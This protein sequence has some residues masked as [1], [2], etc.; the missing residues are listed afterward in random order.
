MFEIGRLI[1][2]IRTALKNETR[3]IN[4]L[5]TFTQHHHQIYFHVPP[6]NISKSLRQINL[7]KMSQFKFYPKPKPIQTNENPENSIASKTTARKKVR[8]TMT[9]ITERP[10][11]RFLGALGN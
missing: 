1:N 3:R 5:Q 2:V 4:N 8:A 6:K 11:A 7:K 10:R 9:G